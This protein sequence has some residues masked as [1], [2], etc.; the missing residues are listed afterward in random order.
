MSPE[1]TL[2]KIAFEFKMNRKLEKLQKKYQKEK[3]KLVLEVYPN[4]EAYDE[5]VQVTKAALDRYTNLDTA[6]H[7]AKKTLKIAENLRQAV[8]TDESI[9]FRYP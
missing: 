3:H 8:Y 4:T 9:R 5:Q 2:Q 1:Y 7:F 6:F